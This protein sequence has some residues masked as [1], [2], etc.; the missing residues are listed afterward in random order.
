MT[1]PIAQL[2]EQVPL[3]DKVPGSTP[4]GRT[5]GTKVAPMAPVSKG[6]RRSGLFFMSRNYTG[7]DGLEGLDE[8]DA[9]AKLMVST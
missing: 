7:E 8:L 3:K 5:R 4:G 6:A 2:A 1:P 9:F